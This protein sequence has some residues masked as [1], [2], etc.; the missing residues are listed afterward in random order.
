MKLIKNIIPDVYGL[1]K[2]RDGWFTPELSGALSTDVAKRLSLHLNSGEGPGTLRLSKMGPMCPHA[3][4]HSVHHPELAE[5]L[6]PWAVIK[7]SY[8]HILEALALC[9]I[10]AA[11]H[12]VTGEQDELH[13]DGIVGH[14]DCVIN[15]AVFDIK[16]TSTY[17]FKKF[18]EGTLWQDDSFGYL[19]QLDG[20]V[21]GSLQDPLV[22]IKDKAYLIAIDKQLGHMALYE[23]KF[24]EEHIRRRIA[25][26]KA[27]VASVSAPACK[28]GTI[29]YGTSGN[30]A[31]DLKA[32]YSSF[33]HVCFPQLRTFLYSKGPVYL[34][35][36]IK[37]P[38]SH[39]V[40]VDKEGRIVYGR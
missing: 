10:K 14:R 23:H 38:E 17:G 2:N 6:P 1:M 37:R 5:P 15:G 7:Y 29:P 33:K 32:S 35:K 21:C 11:G 39:I 16:S 40:E 9:L 34:T 24:R 28:C 30:I 36:V 8:G 13:V 26:Y 31:L 22:R 3:L 27:A 4:W 20:Y 12:E 18:E 25:E 19:E